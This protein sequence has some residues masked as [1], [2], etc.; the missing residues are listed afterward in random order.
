MR[1]SRSM[2]HGR[3]AGRA[4]VVRLFLIAIGLAVIFGCVPYSDQPLSAP[5][6]QNLDNRLYGTWYSKDE[7]ETAFYHFGS[8]AKT[9]LLDIMMVDMRDNGEVE[10]SEL[11]GHNTGID[12]ASYLNLKWVK[13][14]EGSE[15]YLFVKYTIDEKGLGICI[16]DMNVVE[17]AIAAGEI[18]G[19]I[20]KEG[21][22]SSV[23]IKDEPENLRTFVKKRDQ[24]L[25][26]EMQYMSKL[27]A[28]ETR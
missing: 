23:R 7:K 24:E 17:K 19:E 9:G 21:T 25:F 16:I 5:G 22:S 2:H 15:G 3:R 20:I 6:E 1:V 27:Q 12:G 10:Y 13:P 28:S 18:K 14:E 11:V 8:N 4:M 26:P